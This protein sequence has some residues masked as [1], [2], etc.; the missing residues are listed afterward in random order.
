MMIELKYP[1]EEFQQMMN[2]P[3]PTRDFFANRVLEAVFSEPKN[4]QRSITFLTFDADLAIA[5]KAKQ[6]RFPVYFLCCEKNGEPVD[7]FDSRCVLGENAV[8]FACAAGLDGN[9]FSTD[10][11]LAKPF[12]VERA[13]A[14]DLKVMTYGT[15]NSVAEIVK[16]QF[17]LGVDGVIADNVNLLATQLDMKTDPLRVQPTSDVFFSRCIGNLTPDEVSTSFE[18]VST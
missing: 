9:V 7:L 13:K 3:F 16:N 11:L 18:K 15:S 10:V 5:L 2:L 12:L 14:K 4:F 6:V 17:D 8:D 1:V